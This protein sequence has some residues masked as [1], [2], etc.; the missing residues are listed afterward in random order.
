[1]CNMLIMSYSQHTEGVCVARHMNNDLAT[2]AT[3]SVHTSDSGRDS[4]LTSSELS[5]LA[6]ANTTIQ[7]K[8]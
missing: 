1:M 8:M 3:P 4:E 6:T 2:L 5:Q 7:Y